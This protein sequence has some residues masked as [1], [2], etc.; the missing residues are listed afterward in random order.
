M[1]LL[2]DEVPSNNDGNSNDGGGL[3]GGP[4]GSAKA[5]HAGWKR[6]PPATIEKSLEAIAIALDMNVDQQSLSSAD[7]TYSTDDP[8]ERLFTIGA[9]AGIEL[10]ETDFRSPGDCFSIVRQGYPVVFATPS[11]QIF[12]LQRLDGQN[13]EVASVNGELRHEFIGRSQLKR[14]VG[15]YREARMMVAKRELECD[16]MGTHHDHH[17]DGHH[18]HPSPL[19][20]F[21]ALLDLDRRDI[22]TVTLFAAV[23]GV[24]GLATPL[25]IEG[26][27]N[28]VSWGTYFQPLLVL[29]TM[30]LTCLGIAG[31]LKV[32]QTWVVEIIQRRQF[33]RIVSDLSHRFPRANQHSLE[34][35]FPRELANRV[36][37]IMTIQKATATLLVDGI[38]I[39]LTTVLGLFLL[40][41]YHPF[42]LGFDLVLIFTMVI[43][44]WLLGRGG[45]RTAIEESK[46]KYAV[47]H[48]LQDVLAM[49]SAFK[50]GGGESLAVRRC[51][52]LTVEYVNARIRQFRVLIRQTVFAIGLQVVASTA[53]LGLGGWLVIDGQLTLGQ[54]IA[55]E[56]VVTVVVGAFAKAGK[57]IEKFYDMMAAIDKVGHLIDVKPDERVDLAEFPEGPAEVNWSELSFKTPLMNCFV[58]EAHIRAGD[59]VAV[60]GEN[61][62][63]KALLAR[64]LAGLIDPTSGSIQVAGFDTYE[65]VNAEAGELVGYAGSPDVF[66][67]TLRENVDLGRYEVSANRVR[68]ALRYAGLSTVALSMPEGLESRLQTDGYPL[69]HEQCIQLMIARA[70]A[71]HPRLLVIDGCLDMLNRATRTEIFENI[72]SPDAPWTLLV[73][74][75]REDIAAECSTRIALH[76]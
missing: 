24:L 36:F 2:D 51:N 39:I 75:N 13:V 69:S 15:N 31:I 53:L 11:G 67:G 26:L 49:P 42:L 14:L 68:E 34:G 66:H 7:F 10:L 5:S 72:S 17:G 35:E 62:A 58:H 50:T 33:V 45:I 28:V 21:V 16:S 32:L 3:T 46:T 65:A 25:V 20:R 56:L 23:A 43:F 61:Q 52:Q 71:T 18:A 55:S 22:L 4:S 60:I 30:L 47:A 73:I 57:S 1:S 12:V 38:S 9:K 74:T 76:D 48:W 64:G 63:S 37:D 8:L 6:I 40:A 19:Q 54:L 29:A 41:F 70:V 44:T 27:V 59:R